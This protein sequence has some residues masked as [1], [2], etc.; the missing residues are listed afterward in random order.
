MII[1]TEPI[2]SI[3]RPLGLIEEFSAT[4]SAD[5]DARSLYEEAIR[6]TIARFQ[7]TGSPVITDGKQRKY[8]NFGAYCVDGLPNLAPDGLELPFVGHTRRWS[9]LTREPC[10]YHRH[11]DRFLDFARRFTQCPLKLAVISPSPLELMMEHVINRTPPWSPSCAKR[12]S[13]RPPDSPLADRR[14]GWRNATTKK[15]RQP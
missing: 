8:H 7:A 15:R 5:S 12:S 1:A 6:D 10:R 13:P 4:N 11:A 14:P 9:R 2:G 3:P